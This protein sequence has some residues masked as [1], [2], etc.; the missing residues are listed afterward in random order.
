[1]CY[2]AQS[3]G[4]LSSNKQTNPL[5]E[6]K[7]RW[8]NPLFSLNFFFQIVSIDTLTNLNYQYTVARLFFK[9]LIKVFIHNLKS[10]T[11]YFGKT[12]P[13]W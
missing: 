9:E 13:T 10:Q 12:L 6:D 7:L 1:M 2:K 3:I 4:W 5:L 11:I 8:I